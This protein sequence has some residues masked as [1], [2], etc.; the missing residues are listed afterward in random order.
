LNDLIVL[1][2]YEKI[3][4]LLQSPD[5]PSRSRTSRSRRHR[6]TAVAEHGGCG[7]RREAGAAAGAEKLFARSRLAGRNE[8][9]GQ[10]TDL[11]LPRQE[12]INGAGSN[13][14]IVAAAALPNERTPLP[15]CF[16]SMR[17]AGADVGER[18]AAGVWQ[19]VRNLPLPVSDFPASRRLRLAPQTRTASRS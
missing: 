2:P 7:R 18:D 1:V 10:Q 9:S 11:L 6:G 4:I 8:Q 19:V 3:K 14:R 16:C 12:Q 15:P 13:A 5:N 17:N